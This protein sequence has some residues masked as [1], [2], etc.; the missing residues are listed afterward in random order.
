MNFIIYEDEKEFVK[1]YR[2]VI[3][4]LIG[5]SN[6]NYKIIEINEYNEE[7]KQILEKIEGNKIYLLDIEVNG[8]NGLELARRIRNKGDWI[9]PIIIITSHEE[10]KQVGYTAKILMLDFIT[11]SI[12]LEKELYGTLT[13]A[14]EINNSNKMLRF[15]TNGELYSIPYPDILYI[16]KNLNDNT[17]NIVTKNKVYNIRKS[18]VELEKKLSDDISFI[19]THRSCIINLNNVKHVDFENNIIMFNKRETNLLSRAHKKYLKER[20]R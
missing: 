13:I 1:K 11:K 10:F 7:S 14:M 2:D 19:K 12:D 4:K 17:S 20:L 3:H 15:T 16:E 18:I 6:F 8:K 9:S 5:P